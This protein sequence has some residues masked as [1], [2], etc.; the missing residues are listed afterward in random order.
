M[1][2]ETESMAP[3]IGVGVAILGVSFAA[4]LVRWSDSP[5]LTIAVYRF[6]FFSLILLPLVMATSREEIRRL[7]RRDMGIM[8]LIGLMLAMHFFLFISSIKMTSVSNAV[9]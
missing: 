6:V 7:D 4:I 5:P 1:S 3:Y 2:E 8:A 9:L